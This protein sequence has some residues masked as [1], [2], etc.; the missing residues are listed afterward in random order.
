MDIKDVFIGK[1]QKYNHYQEN[2]AAIDY[3]FEKEHSCKTCIRK[4]FSYPYTCNDGWPCGDSGWKDHGAT[5]INWTDDKHC[6]VD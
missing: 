2:I 3:N 6:K 5:C 1:A 4:H